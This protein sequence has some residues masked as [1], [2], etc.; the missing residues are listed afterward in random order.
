MTS[1]WIFCVVAIT[2]ITVH[3]VDKFLYSSHRRQSSIPNSIAHHEQTDNLIVSCV[4]HRFGPII[5]N[6]IEENLGDS[7]DHIAWPGGSQSLTDPDMRSRTIKTIRFLVKKHHL[8]RIH[9]MNHRDCAGHPPQAEGQ[10]MAYHRDQL[11]KAALILRPEIPS[12]EVICYLV[13]FDGVH[14]V[15]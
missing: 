10:E 6:W 1:K 14:Q 4:D 2:G 12:I 8:K 9:L 11:Q 7:A 3:G 5:S 15:D 13:G